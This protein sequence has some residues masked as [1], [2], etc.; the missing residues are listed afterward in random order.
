VQAWYAHGWVGPLAL[1]FDAEMAAD[2][3]EGNLDRPSAD[4]FWCKCA[5]RGYA[6]MKYALLP[7]GP[8]H[9]VPDSEYSSAMNTEMSQPELPFADVVHQLDASDR[10]RSIAELLEAEH[11]G[12]TL[13]EV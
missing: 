1:G 12:D 4:G 5:A 7:S 11:Y 6:G 9:C 3:R 13:L 8:E 10:G 2:L